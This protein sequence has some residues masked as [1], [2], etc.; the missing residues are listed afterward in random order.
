M[1]TK[2]LAGWVVHTMPEDF[3]KGPHAD[4]CGAGSRVVPDPQPTISS[5]KNRFEPSM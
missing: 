2:E 4:A 1:T 5:L 3:T